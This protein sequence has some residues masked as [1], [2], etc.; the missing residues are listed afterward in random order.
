[1]TTM[2]RWVALLCISVKFSHEKPEWAVCGQLVELQDAQ[3]NALPAGKATAD[4]YKCAD[5]RLLDGM[6]TRL[7]Y[8]TE[9]WL[10]LAL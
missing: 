10:Q 7:Q 1:M 6:P 9:T 3:P 5:T 8:P 4:L 2:N